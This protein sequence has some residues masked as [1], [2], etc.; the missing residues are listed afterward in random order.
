M[1][2]ETANRLLQLNRLFYQTFAV[3]F[4]DTRQRLQPG[5]QRVLE[6]LPEQ[7]RILD[8]GCGNGELWRTLRASGRSGLYVGLDF[9][10]GLLE[11]A[12]GAVPEEPS[13]LEGRFLQ[14]DLSEP[15]WDQTLAGF[16][17]EAAGE[18]PGFNTALAFAVLH[19]LPGQELRRKTLQKVWRL[20]R[21]GG[22]FIHSNWQFLNSTRLRQRI[23]PWEAAGLSAGA[24]DPGDALLDW[25]RGGQGLRY[26]HHF[27]EGELHALAQET[28][29]QVLE[30]F[31]SDGENS[32]LGLYQVWGKI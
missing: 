21:P 25:R 22:H 19:H 20:L 23:Q 11:I 8:L 16:W 2:A 31:Y 1:N 4:S 27:E 14:A 5:V 30:S 12:A 6:K 29:F 26:A 13:A 28:G 10:P 17:E 15:D 24:A 9:S 7:V 3:Q 18:I 32:R